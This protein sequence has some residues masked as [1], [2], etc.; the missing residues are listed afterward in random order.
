MEYGNP[1]QSGQTRDRT[2]APCCFFLAKH[3]SVEDVRITAQIP[4]NSKSISS[5]ADP[6]M[7]AANSFRKTHS[8]LATYN[9]C[10]VPCLRQAIEFTHIVSSDS[11]G[12]V[13]RDKLDQRQRRARR[14]PSRVF[15]EAICCYHETIDA[16][17]DRY[18]SKVLRDQRWDC[19]D[20]AWSVFIL[21]EMEV[22]DRYR[23]FSQAQ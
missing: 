23:S 13:A 12:G 21:E 5:H 17:D 10:F 19:K 15:K 20:M 18:M 2:A 16:T 14:G 9:D 22:R 4:K 7:I 8:L 11:A 6:L 3:I 1:Q